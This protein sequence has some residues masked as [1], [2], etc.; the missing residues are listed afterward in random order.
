MSKEKIISL[1]DAV[2][3]GL[4][5]VE[6][7]IDYRPTHSKYRPSKKSTG[8]NARVSPYFETENFG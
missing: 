4:I 8:I 7:Y 2:Q 5:K 3:Q 1:E 6:D